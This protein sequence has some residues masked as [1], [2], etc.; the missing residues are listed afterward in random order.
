MPASLTPDDVRHVA[1]LARLAIDESHVR[2]YAG[3]LESILGYIA[4]INSVDVAGIEPMAHASG[5]VNVLRD[6]TPGEA[7]AVAQVLANA[8][9]ADGAFFSVPKVI[10]SDDP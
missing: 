3:Q 5:L 8:P 1:K 10:G 9:V 6:D 7:L 4:K 2:R